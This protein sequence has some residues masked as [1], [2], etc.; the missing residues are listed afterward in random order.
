MKTSEYL[1]A[2][3]AFIFEE[4]VLAAVFAEPE[5]FGAPFLHDIGDTSESMSR[6]LILLDKCVEIIEIIVTLLHSG[7]ESVVIG[8]DVIV[9]GRL[10]DALLEDLE[11]TLLEL[12]Q[13]SGLSVAFR[14]DVCVVVDWKA[15]LVAAIH[16]GELKKLNVDFGPDW[17]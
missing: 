6:S 10:D 8:V 3:E 12:G 1:L 15:L 17:L 13:G 14:I 9:V 2:V 16:S 4:A 7:L 11:A 5:A